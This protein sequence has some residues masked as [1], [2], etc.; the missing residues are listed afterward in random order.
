MLLTLLGVPE[1]Q[2]KA[3]YLLSS[4]YYFESP[5]VQAQLAAM[6]AAQAAIYR[7]LM[8]VEPAYLQAGFDQVEASYGS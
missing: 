7:H 4:D 8:D 3:D 2:V 6:P 5:A 1:K